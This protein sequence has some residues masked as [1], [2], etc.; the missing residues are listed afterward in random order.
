VPAANPDLIAWI[1]TETTGLEPEADLLLEI[2]VVV[3]RNDL[4]EIGSFDIVIAPN[5]G[6]DDAVSRMDEFVRDMHTSNRLIEDLHDPGAHSPRVADALVAGAIDRLTQGHHGPFL[7]GGSSITHDR[8]FLRVH[9]P[10]TF[11]RLH[12][13]SIDVSGIEQELARDGYADPIAAWR[14]DFTPSNAHRA[15]GDIRDSIRQLSALR[16]IRRGE[17]SSRTGPPIIPA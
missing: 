4:S 16:A 8:G 11:A 14:D 3:T 17:Q 5:E 7:L 2:A 10:Q 1:D 9:A 15:L 13:R 12:Y 6:V